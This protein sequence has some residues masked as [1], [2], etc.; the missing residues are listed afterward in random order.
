[1]LTCLDLFARQI[2]VKPDNE[3][4]RLFRLMKGVVEQY[5]DFETNLSSRLILGLWHPKFIPAAQEHVPTLRRIH[6][7][8]SPAKARQYFWDGCD[9]FSMYFASLV[10]AEG[11]EF[12]RDAQAAGKDIFVWTVNRPDEMVEATRWGVKAVLTDNTDLFQRL[13]S[14]MSTDFNATYARD[15]HPFF[16]WASWQYYGVPQYVLQTIWHADAEKRAGETFEA[17]DER[18]RTVRSPS[19]TSS[20]TQSEDTAIG[21]PPSKAVGTEIEASLGE[22]QAL[23]A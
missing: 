19:R 15:V 1:M 10:R 21:T 23:V 4:D 20:P 7:G 16:R 9:G 3:P 12:M 13:R 5:P 18:A 14:E 2:D 11:Q 6:I 22:P 17:A 8:G